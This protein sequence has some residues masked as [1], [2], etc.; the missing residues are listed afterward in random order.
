MKTFQH[1]LFLI[2][3]LFIDIYTTRHIYQRWLAPKASV[4]DEFRT[5]TETVIDSASELQQLLARYR[6]A[7]EAVR[8]LERQ[9]LGRSPDE[10]QFENQ[11]PFKTEATLRNAIEQ[12]EGKQRE[13]F[14]TRIYWTFG[15]IATVLGLII[16]RK[17]S[18]W[19]GLALMITGF[20]EMIWWCSPSW[21]SQA[22]AETE[23]LL[24][25]KLVLS[26]ATLLLLLLVARLLGLLVDNSG[27]MQ[28]AASAGGSDSGYGRGE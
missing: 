28:K 14:E 6:P 27:T 21:I 20:A 1:V 4:L 2:A 13:L 16:H 3:F 23:R 26:V 11:E 19:L 10:W 7:R 17:A 15:L 5:E 22:S 24:T 18:H 25:N 8:Q 12:W 9:N